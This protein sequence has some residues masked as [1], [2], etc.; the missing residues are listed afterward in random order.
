MFGVGVV[1]L[2]NRPPQHAARLAEHL[3]AFAIKP[4]LR[5]EREF[6]VEEHNLFQADGVLAAIDQASIAER[7]APFPDHF[8]FADVLAAGWDNGARRFQE[9][10]QVEAS[11]LLA[12]RLANDRRSR[13]Q[14]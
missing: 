5:G 2:I 9:C 12:L 8:N 7:A 13:E 4:R 1:A 3:E 11:R 10:L 6:E 14:R